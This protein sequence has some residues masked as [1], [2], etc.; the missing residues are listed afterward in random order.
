MVGSFFGVDKMK[1]M[2]PFCLILAVQAARGVL[3]ILVPTE[4]CLKITACLTITADHHHKEMDM[5][6]SNTRAG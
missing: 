5:V 2:A 1:S 4:R 3:S 6:N